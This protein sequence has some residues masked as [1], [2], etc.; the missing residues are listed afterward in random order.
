MAAGGWSPQPPG[1]ASTA[2]PLCPRWGQEWLC[3]EDRDEP[4]LWVLLVGQEK[5]PWAAGGWI[6]P[7]SALPGASSAPSPGDGLGQLLPWRWLRRPAKPRLAA[8]RG[9]A[10]RFRVS[11]PWKPQL[12]L[13]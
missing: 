6:S 11:L 8:A 5:K 12:K 3:K 7:G 10:V 13:F 2:V 1:S 9:S 4:S